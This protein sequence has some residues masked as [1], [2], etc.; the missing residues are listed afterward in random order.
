MIAEI[1]P[2]M[3]TQPGSQVALDGKLSVDDNS[4][5]C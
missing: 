5:Y 1:N 3:V 2:L 4:L